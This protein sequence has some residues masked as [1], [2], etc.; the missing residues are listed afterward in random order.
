[1]RTICAYDPI[2]YVSPH[3]RGDLICLIVSLHRRR[4][5]I[6]K[7]TDQDATGSRSRNAMRVIVQTAGVFCPKLKLYILSSWILLKI[8]G[9]VLSPDFIR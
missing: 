8:L 4:K 9:Q 7:V 6:G 5:R 3:L 2:F 1:M